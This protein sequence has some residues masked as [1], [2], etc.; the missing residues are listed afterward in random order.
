MSIMTR[1]RP[2]SKNAFSLCE[3]PSGGVDLTSSS[4]RNSAEAP[5]NAQS[6]RE[7]PEASTCR[8]A[9]A[10]DAGERRADDFDSEFTH[11]RSKS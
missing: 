9:E 1:P 11:G 7:A 3:P 6:V 10:P 8:W 4:L 2:I 5:E